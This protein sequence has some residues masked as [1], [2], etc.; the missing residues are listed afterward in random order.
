MK[1]L[2]KV[3]IV[4][5]LGSP[6]MI[7][8]CSTTDGIAEDLGLRDGEI[9]ELN[10]QIAELEVEVEELEDAIVYLVKQLNAANDEITRLEYEH[11][12]ELLE[13]ELELKQAEL[14][15]LTG[16]ENV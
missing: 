2:Q 1:F 3:L 16:E 6:F 5:V 12:I 4:L 14:D 11:Q 13:Y 7:S 9:N 10:A 15:E 8:G